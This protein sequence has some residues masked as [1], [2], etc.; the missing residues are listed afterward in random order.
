MANQN[1]SI[2][3]KKLKLQLTTAIFSLIVLIISGFFVFSPVSLEKVA[4]ALSSNYSKPSGG[5]LD[6]DEWNNLPNDFVAKSGG[7]DAVM[8]GP[9]T[10]P[11]DP[12][13]PMQAATKQ[14]VDNSGGGGGGSDIT[15]TSGTDFKMVC[16]VS[17]TGG[18]LNYG[19]GGYAVETTVDTSAANFVN[20]NVR[21]TVSL[22]GS[23]AGVAMGTDTLY[24]I[25]Q[26]SFDL[27]LQYVGWGGAFPGITGAQANLWGWKVHWCGIGE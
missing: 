26:S 13:Q 4:L 17:S 15:D 2:K 22:S 8:T 9:L 19:S 24:N 1:S 7:A 27:H 25:S 16:G 10:L 6:H 21:Y 23:N 20:N 3:I 18:W 11:A 5:S 12:A 14:Y